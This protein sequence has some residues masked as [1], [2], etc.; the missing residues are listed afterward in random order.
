VQHSLPPDVQVCAVSWHCTGA[1]QTPFRHWSTP[2]LQQGRVAHD[3]SVWAQVGPPGVSLVHVPCVAPGGT[4][5]VRPEQ[6]SA[7]TVQEALSPTQAVRQTP[8]SQ[9]PEQHVASF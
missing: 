5:Q 4:S 6:Q 7:V 9:L 3:W 1:V 2:T 8:F